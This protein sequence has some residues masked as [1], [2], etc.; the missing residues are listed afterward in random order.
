MHVCTG[1]E[2]HRPPFCRNHHQPRW[3]ELETF[4]QSLAAVPGC[5][6]R[7]LHCDHDMVAYSYMART[8]L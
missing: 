7:G 6:P 4:H 3:P 2:Q 5:A 1:R 8:P